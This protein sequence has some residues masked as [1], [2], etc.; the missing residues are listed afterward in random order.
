MFQF[1]SGASRRLLIECLALALTKH[2]DSARMT[3]SITQAVERPILERAEH[4]GLRDI[5]IVAK[6]CE[7]LSESVDKYFLS[8]VRR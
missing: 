8:L 7:T 2:F 5:F 4:G 1:S 3:S 6:L